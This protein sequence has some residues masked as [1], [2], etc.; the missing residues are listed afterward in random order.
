MMIQDA[1]GRT[2][3]SLRVSV[4]DRCNLRCRYCMPEDG[5]QFIDHASILRYEEIERIVRVAV[6]LGIVK[7]RITGGEPLVRKG[8]IAFARRLS[9]IQ[10]IQK[11]SMTTNAI[12]LLQYAVSLKEAGIDY[13]NISLDT[14][15]REKF[16][17]ITRF[18]QFSIVLEGISAAKQAGFALIK[19]N[20]VSVRGFNDD[21]LF[22]FIEFADRYDLVVRF[23][24]Y[25]PFPGNRWEQDRFLPSSELRERLASRYRLLPFEEDPS[26]PAKTYKISGHKGSIGFISAVSESFCAACNRLRLT[27][28]GCLRPCLHGNI[29]IDVKKPLRCGASDEDIARLFWEAANKKPT[30]H[31]NFLDNQ[32]HTPVC[33][34]EMVRIGG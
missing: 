3:T 34:R 17:Q 5:V 20:V 7:I 32:D 13:L 18:D 1:I 16:Y 22:D 15:D 8:I 19:V 6:Q 28:D 12:L 9:L 21:E 25:M 2:I 4:T 11:L 14:L 30:S 24:E 33:D 23:I 29:E 10:G 26:A 27:A 31:Q